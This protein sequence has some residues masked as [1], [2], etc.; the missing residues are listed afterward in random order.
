MA[1]WRQL[2][3]NQHRGDMTKIKLQLA[4]QTERMA[5]HSIKCKEII[6]RH[7]SNLI[8]P[9]MKILVHS[10]SKNVMA[11][12]KSAQDRGISVSVLSIETA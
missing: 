10:F 3:S 5:L 2:A 8:Q 9:G 1:I 11:V 6:T 7:S 4:T 12:I